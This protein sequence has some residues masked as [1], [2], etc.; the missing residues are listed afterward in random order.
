MLYSRT[1]LSDSGRP[2][3]AW[4]RCHQGPPGLQGAGRQRPLRVLAWVSGGGLRATASSDR[5]NGWHDA[6]RW[7]QV[8]GPWGPP[9]GQLPRPLPPAPP[10]GC[11]AV[12]CGSGRGAEVSRWAGRGGVAEAARWPAAMPRAPQGSRGLVQTPGWKAPQSR[13]RLSPR[14][15]GFPWVLCPHGSLFPP[16]ELTR[17]LSWV[18]RCPGPDARLPRTCGAGLCCLLSGEAA[19][20]GLAGLLGGGAELPSAGAFQLSSLAGHPGRFRGRRPLHPGAN[21]ATL[22]SL[23]PW[24]GPGGD[25][26]EGRSACSALALP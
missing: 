2:C 6:A 23:S 14:E 22:R 13:R 16:W 5:G 11:G 25:T 12:L 8:P 19:L 20:L 24:H 18:C 1:W 9:S 15:E 10:G 17:C 4:R 26:G 3:P 7:R 21:P